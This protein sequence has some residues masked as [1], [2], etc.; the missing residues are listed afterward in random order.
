M[1]IKLDD[2]VV[3]R[4]ALTANEVHDAEIT[5]GSDVIRV[6]LVW[7]SV[8]YELGE[9]PVETIVKQEHYAITGIHYDELIGL[10]IGLPQVGKQ[11]MKLFKKAVR[12]KVKELKALQGTVE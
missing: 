8:L 3:V 1:P 12:N 9:P 5:V 6:T 7:K 2:E 4:T 10:T 11:M